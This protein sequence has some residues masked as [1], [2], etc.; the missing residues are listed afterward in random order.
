MCV[1]KISKLLFVSLNRCCFVASAF[2][3][4][5]ITTAVRAHVRT[6]I[7]RDFIR[8]TTTY[9]GEHVPYQAIT[10]KLATANLTYVG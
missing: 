2:W 3:R 8:S 7:T 10:W 6:I 1:K 9:I 4:Y 5:V